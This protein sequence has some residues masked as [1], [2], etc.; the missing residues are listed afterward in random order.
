MNQGGLSPGGL[1]FDCKVRRESTDIDDR[2]IAHI[3]AM[4]CF[5]RGLLAAARIIN[6]K[7][8][9]D[10]VKKRYSSFDTGLGAKAE[11]GTLSFEV[12]YASCL[13]VCIC[14]L[15]CPGR[16]IPVEA[17]AKFGVALFS[18]LLRVYSL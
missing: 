10:M 17:N 11:A 6:D 2:F 1:N 16:C 13:S 3:G 18:V 7:T 14:L 15:I 4:D 8:L 9:A 5:A 12:G